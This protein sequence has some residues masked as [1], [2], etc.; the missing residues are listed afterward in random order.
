[1]RTVEAPA[2]TEGAERGTSVDLDRAAW[3][4]HDPDLGDAGAGV[5]RELRPAVVVARGLGDLDDEQHV[6]R[7]GVPLRVEVGAWLEDAQV[8]LRLGPE[9]ADAWIVNPHD[10][11]TMT[12]GRE[13]RAQAV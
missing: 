2:S 1:V 6:R 10:S 4:V 13:G 11:T 12:P 7:P 3:H 9:A 5:E 8:R